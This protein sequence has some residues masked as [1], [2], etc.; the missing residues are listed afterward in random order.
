MDII[1]REYWRVV[2]HNKGY[3]L[4][5]TLALSSATALDYIAPIFYKEIADGLAQPFSADTL[6]IL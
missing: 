3:F 5:V 6:A 1:F 4:L 2:W